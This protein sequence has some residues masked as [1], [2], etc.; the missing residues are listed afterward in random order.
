MGGPATA[1]KLAERP[2]STA[3]A[4]RRPPWASLSPVGRCYDELLG[5]RRGSVAVFVVVVVI[6]WWVMV[7]P[8]GP[9]ID[10]CAARVEAAPVG[11]TDGA[12]RSRGIA[13]KRGA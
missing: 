4:A 5:S 2:R 1:D 9:V 8:P 10:R 7:M 12:R 11:M 3:G 13:N 6:I